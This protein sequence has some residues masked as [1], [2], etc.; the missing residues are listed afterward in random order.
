[1]P[2]KKPV[3][4]YIIFPEKIPIHDP[5]K[6]NRTE[7]IRQGVRI[8]DLFFMKFCSLR[9]RNTPH[10]RKE[11]FE[12]RNAISR[13]V[14]VK[15]PEFLKGI[16]VKLWNDSYFCDAY[17]NPRVP[18]NEANVAPLQCSNCGVHDIANSERS[19]L[20]DKNVLCC[21]FCEQLKCAVCY[22]PRIGT[23]S[24]SP[25]LPKTDSNVNIGATVRVHCVKC[26]EKIG[27][28]VP[29]S[30]CLQVIL[31]AN[32]NGEELCNVHK[33]NEDTSI[34]TICVLELM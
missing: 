12:W 19:K 2:S 15:L 26:T 4:S 27:D 34:S 6:T 24:S 23:S 13:G 9:N 11:F 32:P 17:L 1:M 30:S 5:R 29:C 25:V 8:A 31:T 7:A 22:F 14:S 18:L 21:P 20:M 16:T 10:N 33:K 28:D 3:M